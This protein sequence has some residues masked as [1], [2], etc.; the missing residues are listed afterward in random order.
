[1]QEI[2]DKELGLLVKQYKPQNAYIIVMDPDNYEIMASAQYLSKNKNGIDI[3]D[4]TF[5]PGSIVKPL[6]I[7]EAI[8]SGVISPDSIFD[9]EGGYWKKKKLRDSHPLNFVTV[10]KIVLDCSN[11]G[12]A[13]IAEKMG[14]EKLYEAFRSFGLGNPDGKGILRPVE[15]WDDFSLSRFPMGCGISVTPFEICRAYCKLMDKKYS[16]VQ[17][18][19]QKKGDEVNGLPIIGASCTSQKW[20]P[21][22]KKYSTENFFSGYIGFLKNSKDGEIKNPVVLVLADSPQGTVYGR[23]VAHSPFLRKLQK[24]YQKRET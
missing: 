12:V 20:N 8:R 1:M 13:K 14:K 3:A 22:T 5:E 10:S 4:L 19:L 24:R 21:K 18:I 6:V 11:I 2:V 9:C 16:K 17:G 23:K 15:K 7:G